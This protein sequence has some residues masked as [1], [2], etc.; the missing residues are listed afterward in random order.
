MEHGMTVLTKDRDFETIK[1]ANPELRVRRL[2]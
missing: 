2:I 1:A